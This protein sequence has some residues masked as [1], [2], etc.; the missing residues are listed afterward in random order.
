MADRDLLII[1]AGISGL[2]MA[3]YAAAAGLNVLVL[4][5]E[6]RVG[7]MPALASFRRRDGRVLAGVGR[8]QRF[9]FLR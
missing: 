2:S 6:D 3:H 1:G 8:A 5:R 7:G 9:Q 4:E